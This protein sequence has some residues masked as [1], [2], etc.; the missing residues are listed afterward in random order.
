[1]RQSSNIVF[2]AVCREVVGAGV[3][4]LSLHPF[5]PALQLQ[6]GRGGETL[7]GPL[8]LGRSLLGRGCSLRPHG[9]L[10]S[11]AGSHVLPEVSWSHG[12]KLT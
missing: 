12:E 6:A 2:P 4:A 7:A 8:P 10:H 3:A 1:M 11:L 9:G 5:L